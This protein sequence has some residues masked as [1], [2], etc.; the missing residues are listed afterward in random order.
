LE[1]PDGAAV[2]TP[3]NPT[4]LTAIAPAHAT[5]T[6]NDFTITSFRYALIVA[7]TGRRAA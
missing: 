6:A 4:L 5:V 2:A 7:L 1:K 3:A